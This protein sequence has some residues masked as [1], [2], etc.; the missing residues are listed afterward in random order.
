M[1]N[2]KLTVLEKLVAWL[3]GGHAYRQIK[4]VVD[5]FMNVE[6]SGEEKRKRVQGIVMPIFTNLS[7]VLIN[8]AIEV[9]VAALRGEIKDAKK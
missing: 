5:T 1:E 6:M 4:A 7:S 9:A 8:I 3:T 2:L